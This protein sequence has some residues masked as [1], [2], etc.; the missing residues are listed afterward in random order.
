M[1]CGVWK[2]G[3]RRFLNSTTITHKFPD[4]LMTEDVFEEHELIINAAVD[5]HHK[6]SD[7]D[8]VDAH[9]LL[10]KWVY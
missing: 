4:S 10:L 1:K 8:H 7:V 6:A 2:Q 9:V 5:G 3:N